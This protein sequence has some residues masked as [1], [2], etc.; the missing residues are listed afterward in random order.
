MGLCHGIT[1]VIAAAK[2]EQSGALDARLHTTARWNA[3]GRTG[4][5]TKQ[6]GAGLQERRVPLNRSFLRCCQVYLL[7]D[8]ANRHCRLA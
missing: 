8:Y 1:S 4:P 3:S 7:R 2:K 5:Y 6:L